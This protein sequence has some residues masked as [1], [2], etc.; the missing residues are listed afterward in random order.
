MSDEQL[1]SE[2]EVALA[3]HVAH[4]TQ[5]LRSLQKE[6]G[7]LPDGAEDY[8]EFLGSPDIN[9]FHEKYH[10]LIN[11][12]LKN[13]KPGDDWVVHFKSYSALDE[14][15]LSQVTAQ[16]SHSR[17]LLKGF[18]WFL[19]RN[20][21][22]RDTVDLVIEDLDQ[23]VIDMRALGCSNWHVHTAVFWQSVRTITSMSVA[24]I[25]SMLPTL[26]ALKKFFVER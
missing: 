16:K 24:G 19:R 14:N 18:R 7:F 13:I 20:G 17:G 21:D 3:A 23:D 4:A 12:M 25:L 1:W 8:Q 26:K 10:D 11:G 9:A 2:G 15:M 6:K 5:A 22:A